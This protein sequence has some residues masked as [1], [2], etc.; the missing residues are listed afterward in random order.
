MS[1]S[2]EVKHKSAGPEGV[3]YIPGQPGT[4]HGLKKRLPSFM[5]E[6]YVDSVIAKHLLRDPENSERIPWDQL[7]DQLGL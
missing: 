7:K 4:V 1:T 6:D 2:V 5:L 3:T